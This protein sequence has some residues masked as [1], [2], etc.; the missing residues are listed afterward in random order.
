MQQPRRV[1]RASG[2]K[3]DEALGQIE[4]EFVGPHTPSI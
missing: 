2:F 3:S 1:A 4:V